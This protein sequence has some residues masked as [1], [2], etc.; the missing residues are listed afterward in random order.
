MSVTTNSIISQFQGK[1][2]K[3]SHESE[4]TK[5]SM[6]VNVYLPPRAK[7]QEG[8]KIPVLLYLS[9]L[10]CTPDNASEKS[11]LQYFAAK[12][13]FAVVFPDTSPRGAEIAGEDE[14]WDFGTGAGFYV[15]ATES[16]W[17]KNYRMYSYIHKELPR[18]LSGA[19]PVLDFENVSIMGH[20]M[21]GYG[22]LSG[23][24]KNP[25]M[26]KSVSAFAPICNPS[27][28]AWG[29]KAFSAYLGPDE[30]LWQEYDPIFLIK[31]YRGSNQPLILIHQG[32]QD[33]FDVKDDQ[34][35]PESLVKAAAGSEYKGTIDLQ[36]RDGDHSYYFIS[37]YI[38]DHAQHHAKALGC[39]N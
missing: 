20:S 38:E 36:V 12:H 1:L 11:F 14:S 28:C 3:V 29:R 7:T 2:H 10:T 18:V 9:G 24:L 31:Q 33:N 35:Q 19:F 13:G 21:G 4:E 39:A 26:Y 25:G 15:D 8:T 23:F 37:S 6:A 27:N 5:T 30:T 16:P 32:A 22:A 17:S 34:L